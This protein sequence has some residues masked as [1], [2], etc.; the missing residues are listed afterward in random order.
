MRRLTGRGPNPSGLCQCG[1]GKRA[2][3]AKR[4]NSDKGHVIGKPVRFIVGHHVHTVPGGPHL[5]HG[6][7]YNGVHGGKASP[8][9]HSWQAMKS[10]CYK[11]TNNRYHRYGARGIQ[12]C[13][14][15]MDKEHGFENF[16]FDM[17]EKP[18]PKRKY[19]LDRYPDNN[20]DY[21]P[22]NC[23]WATA[24]Q[25]MHNR[26]PFKQPLRLKHIA[27]K[28]IVRLYFDAGMSM[29]QISRELRISIPTVSR[30]IEM[31]GRKARPLGINQFTK[32]HEE[33]L[34]EA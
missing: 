2:P 6:H 11:P 32:Q 8:E 10:R 21:G 9:Y 3:I 31:A 24:S 7:S 27:T 12:V 18:K 15:W 14:R 23:R 22:K 34:V 25:Q 4:S 5:K 30:R 28:E 26:R 20:G 29:P 13:D 19:S 1:C 17:G 33:S 16:L